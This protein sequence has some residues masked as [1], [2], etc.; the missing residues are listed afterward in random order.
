M[1]ADEVAGSAARAPYLTIVN[2]VCFR[3]PPASATSLYLPGASALLRG[4][5]LLLRSRPENLNEFPPATPSWVNDPFTA[6]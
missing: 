1:Y 2:P 4:V 5:S 3:E 6:L